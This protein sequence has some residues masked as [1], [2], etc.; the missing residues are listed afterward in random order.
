[1]FFSLKATCFFALNLKGQH[2]H[3]RGTSRSLQPTATILN[4]TLSTSTHACLRCGPPDGQPRD[5]WEWWAAAAA[6]V[7]VAAM[8]SSIGFELN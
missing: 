8:P 2:L 5:I 3:Q 1:M 6:A 7:A 4:P